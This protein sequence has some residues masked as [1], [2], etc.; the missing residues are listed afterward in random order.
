MKEDE[1]DRRVIFGEM[2]CAD[3]GRVILL[4]N[5]KQALYQLLIC[6]PF[7]A[8]VLP[9]S[10]RL[11]YKSTSIFVLISVQ[12]PSFQ[13]LFEFFSQGLFFIYWFSYTC[14]PTLNFRPGLT[15]LLDWSRFKSPNARLLAPRHLAR[16]RSFEWVVSG[17]H[18]L[19]AAYE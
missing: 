6:F 5:F 3:E 8:T 7:L 10:T 15:P 1:G 14:T 19:S 16:A 4:S 17:L 13:V 2:F 9:L 18:D 12:L 11:R